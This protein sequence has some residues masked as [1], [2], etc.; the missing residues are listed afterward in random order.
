MNESRQDA[1]IPSRRSSGFTLVELLVVITII[2]MLMALLLP[3]VQAAREA[4]RRA[5]CLNNLRQIGLALQNYENSHKCFPFLRGGT[6]GPC[7][8]TSNCGY[9]SGWPMLLP[10][11]ELSSLY[12]RFTSSQSLGQVYYPPWGPAPLDP[13]QTGYGPF[14]LEVN[15][16]QCPSSPASLRLAGQ[17]GQ[18]NY[19]FSI[20]DSII[21]NDSL[22]Q[23]RGMF[24]FYT[25]TKVAD[26]TDGL[27][28]T[29][30]VSEAVKGSQPGLIRGSVAFSVLGSDTNPSICAALRGDGGRYIVQAVTRPWVGIYWHAGVPLMNG[31]TT[32]LP[33]NSPSCL[34]GSSWMGPGI[35]SVSSQHP[36][37]VNALYADASAQFVSDTIDCGQIGS[38]EVYGGPSPYGV[39]G[40]LGSKA[41][42]ETAGGG[43]T[44]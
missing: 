36:G 38:P 33:P 6:A 39:W 26:I 13:Y 32:V 1:I 11:F 23:P 2:S 42:G 22:T 43:L 14:N 21:N 29:I 3:A 35:I 25:A 34:F 15:L 12:D 20:G 4:A 37:G 30:A 44:N 19:H 24:G 41:G 5:S 18:T 31:F 27:S 28:N 10:Y 7:D 17:P 9:L 40:A 8:Y 16:L